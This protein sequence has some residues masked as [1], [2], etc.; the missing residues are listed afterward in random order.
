[1]GDFQEEV[2]DYGASGIWA[3]RQVQRSGANAGVPQMVRRAIRSRASGESG[4]ALVLALAVIVALG[5]SVT[6]VA[7]YST[8]NFHSA[9]HSKSAQGALSLAEA[10]LNLAYSTLENASN[11]GMSSALSPTPVADVPMPGGFTTYF[12]AYDS[13][14]KTWT[15]TGV[16]KAVDP[17]HPGQLVVR[18]AHGR[19]H[20]GTASVGSKNN[21]VWNYVYADSTAT[22]TTIG[23]SVNVNVPFYVKGNLCMANSA[24]VTSYALQVGGTVTM[25]STQNQIG[26]SSAPLHEAHIGGGCSTDGVT[27]VSPC[28]STQRVWAGIL[29]DQPL[30]LA[31]PPVDM[32]GTAA[33]A[34]LGPAHGCTTG[35]LPWGGF[36][37]DTN[38]Q[39]VSLG[40]LDLVP[41]GTTYDCKALDPVTHAVVGELGWDGATL[42]IAGTIYLDANISFGQQNHVVYQGKATIYA[43]GSITLGQQTTV[44]GV[45]D[46]G[47]DWDN[48]KNLLAWVAGKQCSANG[49]E[50]DGMSVQNY[51]TFQG[52]IYTV[53]DYRE[54]NNAIVWGPIVSRQVYLNNST[55]NFYVPIG[56]LLPGMPAQYDQVQTIVPEPGSWSS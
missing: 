19:A 26:S 35:S 9:N 6:S 49:S 17:N 45:A 2:P 56:T 13:P 16:G 51:S 14:S 3:L 55:T 50:T 1:L 39:N 31:K 44:C 32:A 38:S 42:T 20:V 43:S 29:D 23:N 8:A 5:A 33:S 48:S 11:P 36:D 22:C 34:P 37:N 4:F 15:L 12:G 28:S 25:T 24:I 46:C 52:A 10:G 30:P 47:T 7:Y 41:K 53:C 21:A 54:G 18:Y 40:T 27:Y